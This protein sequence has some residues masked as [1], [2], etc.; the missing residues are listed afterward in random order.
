MKTFA[1]PSGFFVSNLLGVFV[2]VCVCILTLFI[3]CKHSQV[4]NVVNVHIIPCSLL[5]EIMIE[6]CRAADIF[7]AVLFLFIN[8]SVSI[9]L[10]DL[11]ATDSLKD[12]EQ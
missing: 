1:N 3:V 7:S 4:V 10:D 2:C 12:K 9:S 8:S 6:D 11:S 5:Y